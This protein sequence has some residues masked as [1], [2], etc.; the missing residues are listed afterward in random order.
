MPGLHHGHTGGCFLAGRLWSGDTTQEVLAAAVLGGLA[1]GAS[2]TSGEAGLAGLL[3]P[4][5]LM[6]DLARGCPPE[7]AM[8]ACL[9]ATALARSLRLSEDE[10]S[11]VYYTTLLRYVGCT[12]TS[13]EYAAVFGGDDVSCGV[14]GT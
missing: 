7:E 12:A 8:R 4:L 11:A 14:G 5:S 13:H 6:T 3:V 9:V 2:G 10:A 1:E